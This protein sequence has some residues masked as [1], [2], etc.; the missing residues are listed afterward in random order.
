MEKV[1]PDFINISFRPYCKKCK[2][3]KIHIGDFRKDPRGRESIC[4]YCERSK[5]CENLIKY[6]KEEI[7]EQSNSKDE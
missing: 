4:I 6:L 1:V 7:D 3:P 5:L 2:E